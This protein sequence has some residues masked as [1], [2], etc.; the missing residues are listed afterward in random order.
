[1]TDASTVDES[2]VTNCGMYLPGGRTTLDALI[3]ALVVI[4]LAKALPESMS[5]D[6]H[7]CVLPR[8]ELAGAAEG[9]N[10]NCVLVDRLRVAFEVPCTYLA[11]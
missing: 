9:F 4:V 10:A 5:L 1:M 6:A 3:A 2:T 7:D 11:E 8:I